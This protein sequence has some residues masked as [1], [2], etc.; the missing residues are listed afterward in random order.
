MAGGDIVG[1]SKVWGK[2]SG[3]AQTR[4]QMK[5]SRSISADYDSYHRLFK[6]RMISYISGHDV[7]KVRSTESFTWVQKEELAMGCGGFLFYVE[8]DS[9]ADGRTGGRGYELSQQMLKEERRQQSGLRQCG[10]RHDCE[11]YRS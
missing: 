4:V 11:Q 9:D 5:L 1:A 2:D 6:Q 3:V 7:V 8:Y 10:S